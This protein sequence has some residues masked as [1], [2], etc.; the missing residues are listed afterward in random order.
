[1]VVIVDSP[2]GEKFLQYTFAVFGD[3]GFLET[4][5]MV[6]GS[7]RFEHLFDS[8]RPLL[9]LSFGG[10]GGDVERGGIGR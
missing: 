4:Y 7:K 10:K 2:T 3:Q 1:M 5:D 8:L 6:F 9:V